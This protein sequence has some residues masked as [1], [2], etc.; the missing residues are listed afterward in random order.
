M[1]PEL[2][3]KI[4]QGTFKR[5][6]VSRLSKSDEFMQYEP[7]TEKERLF[8][9]RLEAAIEKGLRDFYLPIYDASF[10]SEGKIVFEA[11]NEPAFLRTF[12]WWKA[13]AVEIGG[14][15]ATRSEYIAFLGVVLKTLVAEGKDVA[16]AWNII[17]NPEKQG[18]EGKENAKEPVVYV[19]E[20]EDENLTPEERNIKFLKKQGLLK[21]I[22]NTGINEMAG[23]FDFKNTYKL[24]L[25]DE[26]VGT[27][28]FLIAGGISTGR[29]TNFAIAD[30]G[31]CFDDDDEKNEYTFFDSVGFIVF[32]L[33]D[34]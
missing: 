8:K 14:R 32:D 34:L 9:G 7:V 33:F 22:K 11:G 25:E 21:Y 23:F 6:E 31:K 18:E 15:L 20:E 1:T 28:G 27:G 29:G 13:A 16:E 2:E 24:V 26:E 10:D 19:Y 17:C 12:K 4:T 5:V 30:L 3:I